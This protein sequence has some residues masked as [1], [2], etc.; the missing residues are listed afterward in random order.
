MDLGTIIALVIVGIIIIS[1]IYFWIKEDQKKKRDE[2][3]MFKLWKTYKRYKK[4]E[5]YD[6]WSMLEQEDKELYNR[7]TQHYGKW[8]LKIGTWD[9]IYP[10]KYLKKVG[11]TTKD[12]IKWDWTKEV[13]VW[14][15]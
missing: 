8:Q 6:F 12:W 5:Y 14:D 2:E 11:W 7:T 9:K 13:E 4:D 3:Q 1:A 15:D 10:K